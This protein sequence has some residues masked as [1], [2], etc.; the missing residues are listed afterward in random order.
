MVLNVF[1]IGPGWDQI[2]LRDMTRISFIYWNKTAGKYNLSMFLPP[3][4]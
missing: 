2:A 3:F 1:E 4:H